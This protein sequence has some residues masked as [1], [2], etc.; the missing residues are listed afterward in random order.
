MTTLDAPQTD[1]P[2]GVIHDIGYQRYDGPRLGRRYLVGSLYLHSLRT[3]F[4]LGRTIKAK[5]FPWLIVGVVGV[6]AAVLTA[7]RAQTGEVALSYAEFPEVLSILIIFFCAIVGPEL[8][9]RDLHSGVLPLY[10]ARPLHRADYALVKLA[11]LVSATFLMLAVPLTVMFAGA[12]FMVD[13]IGAVW[14]ELGDFLPALGYV[15]VHAI[16]YSVLALLVASLVRR[17][18]VAAGAIV[19]AFLLTSPVVAVLSVMPH[20]AANQLAGLASPVTL[21]GGIGDW[22]VEEVGDLDIGPYGP[23]YGLV[24]VGFVVAGI[25]LLLARYRKVAA[26]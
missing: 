17:R 26:R 25:L 21:V 5:I 1:R 20:E 22:T 9:S 4:G 23:L 15:A 3:A 14:D 10:F 2:A 12:A 18:A 6:V 8:A 7:V 24:A 11:A 16:V 13:G 19:G